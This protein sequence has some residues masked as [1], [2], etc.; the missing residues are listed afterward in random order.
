MRYALGVDRCQ[1][2]GKQGRTDDHFDKV[3]HQHGAMVFAR[4]AAMTDA[5]YV[6]EQQ[7]MVRYLD[8]EGG[9]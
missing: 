8:E 6:L 3:M 1:S 2:R 4:F 9:G 7:H 5:N